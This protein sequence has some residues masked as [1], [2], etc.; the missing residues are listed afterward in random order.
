MNDPILEA[1]MNIA[2][3]YPV[4][5]LCF[6]AGGLLVFFG[7]MM[8]V[9]IPSGKWQTRGVILLGT[10]AL[11]AFPGVFPIL[12]TV[13]VGPEADLTNLP[14]WLMPTAYIV[15]PVLGI[16]NGIYGWIESGKKKPAVES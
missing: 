1:Q 2:F 9:I 16:A 14:D 11:I 13:M 12:T 5:T 6:I 15:F 8:A 7:M 3:N 10:G 4:Q